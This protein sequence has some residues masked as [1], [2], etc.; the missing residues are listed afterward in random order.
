MSKSQRRLTV[1]YTQYSIWVSTVMSSITA[2]TQRAFY[3]KVIVA[4]IKFVSSIN[5][6]ELS[7]VKTKCKRRW[8][9]C[10]L[11]PSS[12]H[13]AIYC[14]ADLSTFCKYHY[15]NCMIKS[16]IPLFYVS[17]IEAGLVKYSIPAPTTVMSMSVWR[18]GGFGEAGSV[19]GL[20]YSNWV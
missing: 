5:L 13:P 1:D 20:L 15:L 4:C 6:S 2:S 16:L 17:C 8:S 19:W 12:S 18:G 9:H 14:S 3:L 7:E 10:Y 11:N